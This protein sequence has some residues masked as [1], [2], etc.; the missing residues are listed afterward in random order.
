MRIQEQRLVTFTDALWFAGY[1][2]LALHLFTVIR[3]LHIKIK[4][5]VVIVVSIIQ[6]FL[7]VII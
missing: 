5:K 6:Y 7:L 1:G 2:F 3:S 4:S